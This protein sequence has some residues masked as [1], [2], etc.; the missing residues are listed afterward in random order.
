MVPSHSLTVRIPRHR[1]HKVESL[2][3]P[4]QGGTGSGLECTARTGCMLP[5][6][7]SRARQPVPVRGGGRLDEDVH[8]MSGNVGRSVADLSCSAEECCPC[9]FGEGG[10]GLVGGVEGVG[11]LDGEVGWGEGLLGVVGSM[12]LSGARWWPAPKAA[13]RPVSTQ[14]GSRGLGD[15]GFRHH[16]GI[17]LPVTAGGG[18]TCQRRVGHRSADGDRG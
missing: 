14:G 8:P 10:G 5:Q 3:V 11:G 7:T 18:S 16:P 1:P 17:C 12:S 6:R 15:R 9:E 2:G 13:H 4:F